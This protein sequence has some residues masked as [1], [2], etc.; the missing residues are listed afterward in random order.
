MS[1][2]GARVE[3]RRDLRQDAVLDIKSLNLVRVA[4]PAHK[5]HARDAYSDELPNCQ[6]HDVTIGDVARI[7]TTLNIRIF[8]SI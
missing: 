6:A 1:E 3:L 5:L 7:G 4:G 8:S 2:V